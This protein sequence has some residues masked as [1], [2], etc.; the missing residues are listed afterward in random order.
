M[1]GNGG[2]GFL[3]YSILLYRRS[4]FLSF[5]IDLAVR[6]MSFLSLVSPHLPAPLSAFQHSISFPGAGTFPVTPTCTSCTPYPIHKLFPSRF[7]FSNVLTLGVLD[8]NFVLHP[9]P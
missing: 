3:A 4:S 9:S 8:S 6:T 2:G 1:T 5:P 7:R